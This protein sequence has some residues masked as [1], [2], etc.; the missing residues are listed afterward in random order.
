MPAVHSGRTMK[1]A[2][3]R[4][5]A[6]GRHACCH[7]ARR[8]TPGC[9]CIE[10]SYLSARLQLVRA[11][12][13]GGPLFERC[14]YAMVG[15]WAWRRVS[16]AP[17]RGRVIDLD[18]DGSMAVGLSARIQGSLTTPRRACADPLYARTRRLA[19]HLHERIVCADVTRLASRWTRSLRRFDEGLPSALTERA[20]IT[21][22]R[23]ASFQ[24]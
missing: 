3:C 21:S 10:P 23:V 18:L 9:S 6:P 16:D 22:A 2:G 7:A 1:C 20:L 4:W 11:R 14:A 17:G 8:W 15:A 24:L 5:N 13:A 12:S 19:A